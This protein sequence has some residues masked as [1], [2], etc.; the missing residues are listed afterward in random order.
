VVGQSTKGGKSEDNSLSI[1]EGFD[2]VYEASAQASELNRKFAFAGIALIWVFKTESAGRQIVPPELFLPG[3]LIAIG[4]ACDL[5]QYVV[6]SEL[7]LIETKKKEKA[8]K[9]HFVV[10]PNIGRVVDTFY[11]LK[12]LAVL[13][14]YVLL[15]RF[16]S[17]QVF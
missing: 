17:K 14:A 2:T 11:W 16:L 1:A 8:K 15:I 4:L 7:W 3:L 9:T 13:A 12:I 10:S 6:K 5:L